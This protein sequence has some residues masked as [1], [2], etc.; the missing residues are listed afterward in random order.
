MTTVITRYFENAAKA[1]MVT[2]ELVYRQRLSRSIIDSYT[3]ADG[4]KGLVASG[5]MAQET[6]DAYAARLANGGV[7]MLVM[8][9]FRPL[10]VA[11]TTRT[12]MADMGAVDM[13]D[14]VEEQTVKGDVNPKN[15]VISGTSLMLT[16][17]LDSR[18]T[19]FPMADW[20]IPLISR[21]KPFA[22]ALFDKHAR[23]ADFPIRLLSK[24]KPYSDMIY[25]NRHQRMATFPI[26]L[27]VPGQKYMAK[28]PFAHIVPG[29]KHYAEWPIDHL[30]PDHKYMAN[31]IWPHTKKKTA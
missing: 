19:N 13:G 15:S 20:P 30:V 28:F 18:R 8:A 7:V 12:V 6:A 16:R 29:H 21:R 5:R 25:V 26:G 31:W 4:L 17:Q 1:T 23:M 14:V 24:R 11:K 2:E 9:G 27:L 10:G 22:R 3:S